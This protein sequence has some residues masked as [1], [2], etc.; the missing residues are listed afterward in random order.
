LQGNLGT[1]RQDKI[2]K[3]AS[4]ISEAAGVVPFIASI[5]TSSAESLAIILDLILIEHLSR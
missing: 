5:S 4:F 1:K 3:Q 2:A